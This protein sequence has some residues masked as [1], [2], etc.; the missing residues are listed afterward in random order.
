MPILQ[1]F[2]CGT[3]VISSNRGSLPEIGGNSAVYFNPANLSQFIVLVKEILEDK[4]LQDKLSKLGLKRALEF[5]WKKVA[6]QTK[7]VYLKVT[8]NA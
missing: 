7:N 8:G 6:Q 2:A 1:A 3:P 5:S 4:S